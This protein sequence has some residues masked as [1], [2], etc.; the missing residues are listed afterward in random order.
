[1]WYEGPSDA[2]ARGLGRR[3]RD[4]RDRSALDRLIDEA[5][6][7]SSVPMHGHKNAAGF[8]SSRVVFHTADRRI[9]TL[10]ENFRAIQERLKGHCWEL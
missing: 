10:T 7:V 4:H 2:L 3:V 6:A 9:P 1:M 8:D 5:I